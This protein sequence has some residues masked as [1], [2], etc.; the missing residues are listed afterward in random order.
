MTRTAYLRHLNN[1]M[2]NKTD[3]DVILAI[4][5]MMGSQVVMDINALTEVYNKMTQTVLKN[6]LL[7]KVRISQVLQ[8]RKNGLIIKDHVTLNIKVLTRGTKKFICLYNVK[9]SNRDRNKT[10]LHH[11]VS[12]KWEFYCALFE[13]VYHETPGK[14]GLEED[15]YGRV[16]LGIDEGVE[17]KAGIM[18]DIAAMKVRFQELIASNDVAGLRNMAYALF[19]DKQFVNP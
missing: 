8:F 16:R 12:I 5:M 11:H 7:K 14:H 6:K 17:M 13:T 9:K 3:K 19:K 1:I 10:F 2:T 4:C 18:R 15:G